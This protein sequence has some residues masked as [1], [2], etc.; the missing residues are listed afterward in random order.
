ML[1]RTNAAYIQHLVKVIM[2][3]AIAESVV[4][5]SGLQSQFSAYCVSL[6][7][8]SK[9][10]K[11]AADVCAF[12]LTLRAAL[13]SLHIIK[14]G[15]DGGE[16]NVTVSDFTDLYDGPLPTYSNLKNYAWK[17]VSELDCVRSLIHAFVIANVVQDMMYHTL[18]ILTYNG[19]PLQNIK[20]Q[21]FCQDTTSYFS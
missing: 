3:T 2:D 12:S 5:K 18:L 6:Y 7:L 14:C 9:V 16:G 17:I 19:L 4:S 20:K 21:I 8:I 10:L 11:K 13:R 15:Q 1:I